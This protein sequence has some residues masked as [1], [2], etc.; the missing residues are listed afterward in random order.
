MKSLVRLVVVIGVAH[1]AGLARAECPDP[2]PDT[3]SREQLRGCIDE[4]LK[5]KSDVARLQSSQATQPPA[6]SVRFEAHRIEQSGIETEGRH[7]VEFANTGGFIPVPDTDS[8]QLCT[9]SSVF[10]NKGDP[11]SCELHFD[12][13]KWLIQVKP[14][15]VC[16]VTCFKL[17][18]GHP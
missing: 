17:F 4:L 15:L 12:D 16:R 1:Y 2:F 11:G 9:L 7:I 5:L 8:T 10:N 14:S 13:G 18:V 6:G 3:P